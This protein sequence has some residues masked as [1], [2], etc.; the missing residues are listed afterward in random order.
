M[1]P[2]DGMRMHFVIQETTYLP[3]KVGE[4]IYLYKPSP[5]AK[6]EYECHS[7]LSCLVKIPG[8]AGSVDLVIRCLFPPPLSPPPLCFLFCMYPL[9][10]HFVLMECPVLY[11]ALAFS[12]HQGQCLLLS[13]EDFPSHLYENLGHL[14]TWVW[15]IDLSRDWWMGIGKAVECLLGRNIYF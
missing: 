4:V 2:S 7:L 8:Q 1:V 13:S 12:W 14:L 5:S 15:T 10:V 9:S 6:L 11:Q 3:Q